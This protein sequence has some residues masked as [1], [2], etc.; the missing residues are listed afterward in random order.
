[1]V[2]LYNGPNAFWMTEWPIEWCPSLCEHSKFP[3]MQLSIRESQAVSKERN[4]RRSYYGTKNAHWL[5]ELKHTLGPQSFSPDT[6]YIL[7][8]CK[9][10]E[11]AEFSHLYS[12]LHSSQLFFFHLLC[13]R[14]EEGGMEK[15]CSSCLSWV[16][17]GSLMSKVR[18]S[19][20]SWLRR[21]LRWQV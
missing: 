14:Q 21:D 3:K 7:F 11:V 2:L 8:F 16:L 9:S 18:E 5:E 15:E 12:P 13:G 17:K 6:G 20:L 4:K 10:S 1:M 19:V